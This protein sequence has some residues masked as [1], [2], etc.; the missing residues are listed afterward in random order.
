MID[1]YTYRNEPAFINCIDS[2]N[3]R[4]SIEVTLIKITHYYFNNFKICP[5]ELLNK[6]IN[7]ITF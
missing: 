5:A 4:Y 1:F 7:K 3:V 2:I 6:I